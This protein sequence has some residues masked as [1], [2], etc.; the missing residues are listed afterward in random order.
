ML[1]VSRSNLIGLFLALVIEDIVKRLNVVVEVLFDLFERASIV[2]KVFDGF[3][4]GADFFRPDFSH[5]GF[6]EF[7]EGFLSG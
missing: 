5:H 1:S 7:G 4:D 2:F 3:V 6:V